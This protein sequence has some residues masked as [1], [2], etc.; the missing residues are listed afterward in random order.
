[1]KRPGSP[2]RPR[3]QPRLSLLGRTILVT[4]ARH[5]A[6]RLSTDLVALGAEVIEIPTIEITPPASYEPL[7]DALRNLAGYNW[8]IVTS[9]NTV[10][11]LRERMGLLGLSLSAFSHLEIAAVGSAT[12]ET[13][14][15]FGLKVAFM[16]H[17]Y[18]AE[19]LIDA[20]EDQIRGQSVLLVRAAAAR[21]IIPETL[22][23][24]GMPVHVVDAYR[25]AIPS[26]SVEQIQAVFREG[27]RIPDAATF[28]SSSTVTNFLAL[29]REAGIDHGMHSMR[30]ISI[31]PVTSQTLREQGWYSS[32]EADPHTIPGLIA[33][34][35]EALRPIN[36]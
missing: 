24:R 8:L 35:V 7:D 28:T 22:R 2:G 30:A 31:G 23:E 16:P 11:V 1:M 21:D 27:A 6:A 4:R 29:L 15:E 26:G 36:H 17:E 20:L 3:S 5:Q 9:S 14:R 32:G 34:T 10:R 13:I 12:A 18:V 25:T 33:A 19:S